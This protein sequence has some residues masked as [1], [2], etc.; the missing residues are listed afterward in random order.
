MKGNDRML[1]RVTGLRVT[2]LLMAAML[3]AAGASAQESAQGF[4]PSKLKGPAKGAPNEVLVLGTAHLSQLPAAFQPAALRTLNERLL[5]WKPRIIAIERLSGTQCAFMRQY[6]HRYKDSVETYCWDTAPARAATGLD[7]PAATVEIDRL[8]ASWTAAPTPSQRRHLAAVFLAGGEPVSALVQWLRLP[9]TERHAGDGLDAAL[10]NVLD[11]RQGGRGARGEDALIAAPLAAALGLERVVSMDDHTGVS[12][13]VDP[14]AYDQ[15][16]GKAWDNPATAKRRQMDERL[17]ARLGEADGVMAL[18]RALNDPSNARLTYDSDFGAALEEGSPQQF[19]RGY[20]TY[21]ETRNLRMASNIR[22]AIGNLPGSRT[23]VIVG[24]SHKWYLEAYLNQMHDVRIVSSDQVLGAETSLPLP[25]QFRL[26]HIAA[27]K[28]RADYV[29]AEPVTSINLGPKVGDYRKQAWRI[30]TPG[31]SLM[32]LPDQESISGGG[33]A[34]SKFSVEVSLYL[35]YEQGNYTAFDRMADGG[36]DIF[37]GFFAGDAVQGKHT[38]PMHLNL[39]LKGLANETVIAPDDHDS[40]QLAY[41]YFGPARPAP[42]GAA[43]LILDPKT[44][45]WVA[46]VLQEA[47]AK[48]TAFYDHAFQRPLSYKPLVM[49]SMGDV[50]TPGMSSKGGA[51]GKQVVYRLSGKALLGGSPQVRKM[52]T[53]LIAHEL[54]HVWQNNVARGGIGG[55]EPWIHEGGAEAIALAGLR[56]SG[57]FS[58]A[59]ADAYAARLVQECETLKGSVESYR[60]FYACGFKRFAD[61]RTDI[62]PLWKSMM[63]TTEASGAVYSAAMIE[64]IRNEGRR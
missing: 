29:L 21:W 38:R 22:E 8:L 60:G 2:G 64:A 33:K 59:D 41:A 51:V 53:S 46:D 16:I 17:H 3:C 47:T 23:L 1:Q 52:L 55:N 50:E 57:L 63:E 4:D 32:E 13:D 11:K 44:P 25:V 12:A 24:A 37:L 58:Q 18:Y 28:W 31:L 43:D 62:L 49:V 61:Y 26:T 48:I 10:V 54:A 7:V 9:E 45:A 6:P 5:A 36:T 35:P 30:L 27:D 20:V 15:A 39:Q 56:G 14:K 34:F 40:D 42:A 19:G